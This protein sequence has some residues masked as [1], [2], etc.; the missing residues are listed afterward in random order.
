ME[1]TV[2]SSKTCSQCKMFKNRLD[3]KNIPY[4][5]IQ[6]EEKAMKIAESVGLYVLPLIE[7]DGTI[8]TLQSA[9]KV[10]GL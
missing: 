4:F 6:D 3:Q 2:Y 9:A 1:I 10:I 7:I 5:D 8:H